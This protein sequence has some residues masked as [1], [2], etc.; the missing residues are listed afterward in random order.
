MSDAQPDG[1]QSPTEE[2]Q[3]LYTELALHPRK[4]FGW[5][6]GRENARNLG[7]DARW[8]DH[9]PDVVWESTAAVGNPFSLGSITL[10]ETVVDL[11]C[12]AGADL[13]IVASLIGVRGRA[14]EIDITPA[15]VD[16]AKEK[17]TAPGAEERRG[18]RRRHCGRSFGRCLRRR[19]DLER[20]DKPV[21]AQ[22]L[23]LPRG[24]PHPQ[25]G[26]SIPVRRHGAGLRCSDPELRLL[27]RLHLRDCRTPSVS[28][29]A[30]RGGLWGRGA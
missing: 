24:I 7:Y 20:R 6:K 1:L 8:L 17:R 29:H 14:I 22:A 12:G 5:G 30:R 11:G 13:C 27:G 16:W 28:R 18:P 15:M 19:R 3:V 10:G 23:R 4:D 26:R 2:I 25:T 9:L 21:A